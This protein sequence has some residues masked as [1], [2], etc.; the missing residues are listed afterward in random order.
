MEH[1]PGQALKAEE[2]ANAKSW[3][4]E[5]AGPIHQVAQHSTETR[6]K[7][8]R[9]AA[10]MRREKL[11][12]PE[13]GAE[14]LARYLTKSHPEVLCAVPGDYWHMGSPSLPHSLKH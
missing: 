1:E 13:S 6:E 8:M 3:R 2:T 9:R 7:D 10:E 14:V 12:K 4:C 11:E 5:R